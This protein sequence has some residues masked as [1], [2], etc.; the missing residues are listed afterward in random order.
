M[1]Y[2]NQNNYSNYKY[3]SSSNPKATIK[4]GGC[5]VTV[6]AMI[7]SNMTTTKLT[8][9]ECAKISINNGARV[10]GGTD[11]AKLSKVICQKYPLVY[12]TTNDEAK[13]QQHLLNGG[14]AI[15]NVGGNRKGW[16]G[17]FSD[18]GHYIVVC[19]YNRTTHKATI[20]DPGY[21]SGKFN[22]AARKGRV[23]VSGNYCYATL[24]TLHFDTYNRNP[25]YYLFSRT[26]K[27]VVNCKEADLAADGKIYIRG[28]SG[29][30]YVINPINGNILVNG[31][32]VSRSDSNYKHTLVAL[33][34]DTGKNF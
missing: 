4:T 13:L 11:M 29:K 33:N 18:S 1:I 22:K 14:M 3:P 6:M 31:R 7:V 15:A 21:Y 32:V 5:G 34:A 26:K 8:P 27:Y 23:N 25:N 19:G 24:E 9:P 2:Y 10:S 16:T 20:M 30:E 28:G 17:V 12:T